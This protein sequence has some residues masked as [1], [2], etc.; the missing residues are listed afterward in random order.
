MDV[1]R[2]REI[3]GLIEMI[4]IKGQLGEKEVKAKIDTGADR[5]SVDLQ[6]AAE[7]GL[8]PIIRTVKVR[9]SLGRESKT[10]L[11]TH[12]EIVIH[13]DHFKKIAVSLEDRS[14]MRYD[15]LLGKDILQQCKF[16]IDPTKE[17]IS[18]TDRYRE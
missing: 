16:L 9:S 1:Q 12:A 3:I 2:D 8:G 6:L 15:V 7:I 17:L 11:I 13:G 5:T 14:M 4:V 18:H 10:R